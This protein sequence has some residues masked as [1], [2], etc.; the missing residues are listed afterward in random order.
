VKGLTTK[1]VKTY[2]K[3]EEKAGKQAVILV[4]GYPQLLD[5]SGKGMAI[6]QYEALLVANNVS[7]FNDLFLDIISTLAGSS[8]AAT[9]TEHHSMIEEV[10]AANYT[11]NTPMNIHFVDVERAFIG[12]AAYSVDANGDVDEWI[13]GIIMPCKDEDL[14]HDGF[15]SSYSIHPNKRG[16]QAYAECVN[17]KIREIEASKMYKKVS[18]VITIADTDTDMTN[19]Q[20]LGMAEIRISNIGVLYDI[21]YSNC[22]GQYTLDNIPAGTYTLKVSKS[23]YITVT[24]TIVVD[25]SDTE[26]I[27][28]ITIEAIS[29]SHNGFGYVSGTIYDVGT[30]LPVSGLTLYVREGLGNT[31]GNVI[32]SQ[33]M[34]D[35]TGYAFKALP[36]GNYTIEIVDERT[37]ISEEER[38]ITSSF[39][40]K[41]LGDI[42]IDNQNGYV[43]NGITSE[44]LR[45]VLTWGAQ[46]YDLDSHLIVP[47]ADGGKYHIFYGDKTYGSQADLDVDD[48]DSYGPE[49]V[50]IRSFNEGIYTYAIHDYSNGGAEYSTAMAASGAQVKVYRG[51]QL[52]ATYNVPSNLDGTLWTVFTYNGVTKQLT[53]VNTMSYDSSS[54]GS[55]LSTFAL[56]P[57]EPEIGEDDEASALIIQDIYS[58]EK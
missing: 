11:S 47:T 34:G 13:N 14:D 10:I 23:G 45:I 50:T 57:E 44:T 42:C 19:N 55:L 49:T 56:E 9:R 16:A 25:D 12:H 7:K 1:L 29:E 2:Q 20:P 40:I 6:N 41:V 38:Y 15:V 52:I 21:T 24:E 27:Y 5:P 51:T 8:T 58:N 54:G 35:S 43:S 37:G 32:V 48:T 30:G 36:A 31:T 22:S 28:N 53:T 39:H 17:A 18:G 46:P 33:E 26:V 3:V 4:A